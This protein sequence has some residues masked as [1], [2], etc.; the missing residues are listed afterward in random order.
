MKQRAAVSGMDRLIKP[1][2]K[3]IPDIRSVLDLDL[4]DEASQARA[5]RH[6]EA[7]HVHIPRLPKVGRLVVIRAEE[8]GWLPRHPKLGWKAKQA[9]EVHSVPGVHEDFLRNHS[10]KDVA[11]AMRKILG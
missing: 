7:L 9:I 2:G 5:T 6:W 10:A 4:L 3:K 1:G 8:E 11:Q